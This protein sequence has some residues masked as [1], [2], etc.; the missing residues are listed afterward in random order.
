MLRFLLCRSVCPPQATAILEER[1]ESQRAAAEDQLQNMKSSHASQMEHYH[2]TYKKQIDALHERYSDST[3][4]NY[5][6]FEALRTES[7]ESVQH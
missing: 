3:V 4:T 2:S 6:K 1:L 5:S 7:E